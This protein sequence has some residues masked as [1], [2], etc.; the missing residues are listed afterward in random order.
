[1][2]KQLEEEELR[3]GNDDTSSSVAAPK[4]TGEETGRRW[5]GKEKEVYH[6]QEEAPRKVNFVEDRD[7]RESQ[8]R[9]TSQG[10]HPTNNG[11]AAF[12]P[13]PPARPL[14]EKEPL[15][16]KGNPK[17]EQMREYT[18]DKA[19]SVHTRNTIPINAPP[20]EKILRT[21]SD[22]LPEMSL[23]VLTP[24][25][26]RRLQTEF[27]DMR[28]NA[29]DRSQKCPYQGCKRVFK[30]SETNR[31]QQHLWNVHVG[32]RCNFCDVVLYEYWTEDQRRQHL[33]G[34]IG[35]TG[36]SG[37]EKQD[38]A[39]V[40]EDPEADAAFVRSAAE[41]RDRYLK[42]K[43]KFCPA[44][45]EPIGRLNPEHLMR[46]LEERHGL[47]E[48][49]CEFCELDFSK[50]GKAFTTR[51]AR[52]AHLSKHVYPDVSTTAAKEKAAREKAA[53]EKEAKEKEAKEMEAKEK[54]ALGQSYLKVV[55]DLQ[56]S[57]QEGYRMKE[58][59]A[60]LK[61]KLQ[62]AAGTAVETAGGQA[63]QRAAAVGKTT[64]DKPVADKPATSK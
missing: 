48:K 45:K 29:L 62:R 55:K 36:D 25:E 20:V 26:Q 21:G 33:L 19:P 23:G 22:S 56:E 42:A 60:A 24:T 59:L 39:E 27:Y 12:R 13:Y 44:C 10:N 53:R 17:P 50:Q 32:D 4:D 64:E 63:A 41:L 6:P 3:K 5:K 37:R 31:L 58:E 49:S 30:I 1:M 18:W 14:R 46:H 7:P 34:H 51:N 9:R 11:A 2:T 8:F 52:V 40:E 16:E 35:H 61:E 28:N 43:P 38:N 47:G 54:A 15:G 57:R